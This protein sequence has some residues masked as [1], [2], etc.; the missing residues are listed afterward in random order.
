M[1]SI[2]VVRDCTG[3]T[4]TIA[5][6]ICDSLGEAQSVES[7]VSLAASVAAKDLSRPVLAVP[8][9][10]PLAQVNDLYLLIRHFDILNTVQSKNG[11]NTKRILRRITSL[12]IRNSC[13]RFLTIHAYSTRR[14][15][16][17][18]ILYN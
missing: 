7:W 14:T 5:D 2:S 17:R 10:L 16:H 13:T 15:L 6:C 8:L 11:R 1:V 4:F 18:F 9:P 12:R 3:L